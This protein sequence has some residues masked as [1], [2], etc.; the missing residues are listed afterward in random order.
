MVNNVQG[1]L[2]FSVMVAV[3]FMKSPVELGKWR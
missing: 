2:V 1:E 3:G